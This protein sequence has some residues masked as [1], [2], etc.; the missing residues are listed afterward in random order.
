MNLGDL[1]YSLWSPKD[2]VSVEIGSGI[3]PDTELLLSVALPL[4]VHICVY[5]VRI[6]AQV[7][8]ELE[9]YFVVIRPLRRQLYVHKRKNRVIIKLISNPKCR[10][11]NNVY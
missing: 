8:Q 3:K 9:I 1:H 2:G 7:P 10:T 6:A 4:R 11:F 5:R